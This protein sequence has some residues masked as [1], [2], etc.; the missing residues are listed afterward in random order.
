MKHPWARTPNASPLS[1]SSLSSDASGETDQEKQRQLLAIRNNK[2]IAKR[3]GWKRLALWATII[4][5]CL[6]GLVAGLVIGLRNR[7]NN[8]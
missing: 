3:G 2:Q 1:Y 5:C 4:S 6:V 8:L 7:N